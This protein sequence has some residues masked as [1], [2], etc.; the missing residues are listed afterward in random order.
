MKKQ[1]ISL[2]GQIVV[3]MLSNVELLY[4]KGIVEDVVTN[5][6]EGHINRAQ[7]TEVALRFK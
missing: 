7:H 1:I 4:Y 3:P 2:L 5:F 6:Q